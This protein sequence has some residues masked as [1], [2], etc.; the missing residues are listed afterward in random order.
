[1]PIQRI[2]ALS[3]PFPYPFSN[4]EQGLR[5]RK[6]LFFEQ[7]VHRHLVHDIA[8]I[9]VLSKA[10]GGNERRHN[11]VRC[12]SLVNKSR[13]TLAQFQI[14]SLI[15]MGN[16]TFKHQMRNTHENYSFNNIF[17]SAI[18]N[19]LPPKKSKS[20]YSE[21]SL[22]RDCCAISNNFSKAT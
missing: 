22:I 8:C 13:L 4:L 11:P 5:V 14:F 3:I 6:L 9:A 20:N 21:K 18:N 15:Y 19:I 12:A 17:T 1:M 7:V 16:L 10:V 2:L